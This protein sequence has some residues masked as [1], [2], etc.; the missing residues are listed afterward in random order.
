MGLGLNPF[1]AVASSCEME[2]ITTMSQ[3][4][5]C[6]D[7]WH[8]STVVQGCIL[9]LLRW[10][11]DV[12]AEGDPEISSKREYVLIP[13]PL[14][15]GVLTIHLTRWT[16]SEM[17]YCTGTICTQFSDHMLSRFSP[18][19][20][21]S[22]FLCVSTW[23]YP[24]PVPIVPLAISSLYTPPD[25]STQNVPCMPLLFVEAFVDGLHL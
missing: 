17:G 22:P 15:G 4:S 24:R 11:W 8:V 7:P 16:I 13:F 25:P 23:S 19:G 3:V 14:L 10:P 1:G 12:A 6:E 9:Q 18:C 2:I 5:R 20:L 21:R